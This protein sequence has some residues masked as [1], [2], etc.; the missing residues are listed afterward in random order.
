[1]KKTNITVVGAL[2]R[3]GKILINRISKNNNLKLLSLIDL[4]IKYLKN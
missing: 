2:G 1:M 4:K 3:M